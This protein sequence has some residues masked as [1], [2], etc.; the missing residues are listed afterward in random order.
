MEWDYYGFRTDNSDSLA[1]GAKGKCRLSFISSLYLLIDSLRLKDV[2][3]FLI[4]KIL[5]LRLFQYQPC[6][7]QSFWTSSNLSAIAQH[8]AA[9]EKD[10]SSSFPFSSSK[11]SFTTTIVSSRRE[12]ETL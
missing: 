12:A 5:L 2:R 10:K 7:N 1:S 3:A 6:L 9:Y 8:I 11:L 4:A